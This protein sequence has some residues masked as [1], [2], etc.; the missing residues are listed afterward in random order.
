M[1]LAARDSLEDVLER[2]RADERRRALQALLAR[3]LLRAGHPAFPLVRRHGKELRDWLA[4]ET[5]WM[6]QLEG[7]FARLHKRPA[8]H[9]DATRPAPPGHRRQGVPA[10]DRRR[11]ALLC[12][13]LA[14]LERGESQVTLGRLGEQVVAGAAAPE[15]QGA[16]IRFALEGRDDRRDLVLVVRLLLDLAVLARVAGDEESY[17]AQERDVLYDVDRRVLASLLVSARGPSLLPEAEAPEGVDARIE[18]ISSHYVPDTAEARN[19]ELR[20]RLTRRLLDDPVVYWDELPE[21]ERAYLT[22]QRVA[23]TRRIEEATGLVPEVRAEGIAMVDPGL[24]L[25]DERMPAEGTEGHV[26]LLLAEHLAHA[27]GPVP[28]ADLERQVRAWAGRYGRYWK[29]SA[30]EPGAE[31]GLV[32]QALERLAALRLVRLEADTVAPLPAIGRFKLE[33]ARTGAGE[34][35]DLTP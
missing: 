20:Q 24:D 26:T 11:Y 35:L 6:L 5:G 10:F 34:A 19:R 25:S 16:G 12:L 31:A 27:G 32:A 15:L 18:A 30:R 4:R 23:V 9:S 2:N 29:K 17:V 7:D 28:R 1:A 22:S 33:A 13:A 8:D 21:D 14:A 3:P